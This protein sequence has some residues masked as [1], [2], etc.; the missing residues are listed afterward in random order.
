MTFLASRLTFVL[1]QVLDVVSTLCALRL[2]MS[3]ANPV[4]R[5]YFTVFGPTVGLLAVKLVT[6]S[7]IFW[8][9]RTRNYSFAF[10]NAL[11]GFVVVWNVLFLGLRVIAILL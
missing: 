2:G 8:W 1:V 5:G 7:A 10:V 3:E 9:I 6:A 4:L 11:F